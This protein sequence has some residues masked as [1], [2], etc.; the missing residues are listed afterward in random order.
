VLPARAAVQVVAALAFA[1]AALPVGAAALPG[2]PLAPASA[3]QG[4]K[5]AQQTTVL[6]HKMVGSD[7]LFDVSVGITSNASAASVVKLKIATL[8]RRATTGGPRHRTTVRVRLWIS[9]RTLTIRATAQRV[10]PTLTVTLVKVDNVAA[11]QTADPGQPNRPQGRNKT[12][13]NSGSLDSTLSGWSNQSCPDGVTVVSNPTGARGY[14]AKF[15][16]SDTSTDANCPLVPTENP[17]AQLVGP[18]MFKPGDDRYIAF[19]TFFPAGFP[20]TTD[21]F[22]IAEIYGAPWGGSPPIGIDVVGNRLTLDTGMA[23]HGAIWT[24]STDIA[25]G[26]GWEDIVLHVK[27]STDPSVGFVELWRNGV[28]Q[29]FTDGSQRF[30]YDTLVPGVNDGSPNSLILNEYRSGS[31]PMGTVWLYHA[32]VKVG[33]SYASVAP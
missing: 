4:A 25:K 13:S 5:A 10:K 17:R 6:L 9:G 15:T 24:S 31:T 8:E 33:T 7:G 20:T 12:R 27:F 29:T 14:A 18:G 21:W 30:Y 19:S 2:G 22:Q 11:P 23:H 16:V 3:S 28:R 26:T 1:G 32:D